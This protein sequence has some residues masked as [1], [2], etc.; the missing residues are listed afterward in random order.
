MPKFKTNT[1]LC[2]LLSTALLG[3]F[4]AKSQTQEPV[5]SYIP[6]SPNAMAFQ[7]FADYPVDFSTGLPAIDIPIYTIAFKDYSFPITASFHAS[8]RSTTFNFSSL[9]MNWELMAT[10]VI[11]REIRGRS[12][13]DGGPHI[14]K[15]PGDLSPQSAHYTELEQMDPQGKEFLPSGGSP[16]KKDNQYDIYTISLNGLSSKFVIKDN[17]NVVFLNYCPYTVTRTQDQFTIIDDKGIS[18]VFGKDASGYG[19]N[20][21]NKASGVNEFTSWFINKITTSTGHSIRFK[22]DVLIVDPQTAIGT[23]AYADTKQITDAG[24]YNDHAAAYPSGNPS[25]QFTGAYTMKF[26]DATVSTGDEYY[27]GYIKDIEFD[28]GTISFTY[29]GTPSQFLLSSVV[30]RNSLGA[31]IKAAN[32]IYFSSLPGTNLPLPNNNSR[33][34]QN[35]NFM[36]STGAIAEKY[37]FEY[38][39][40][41]TG[42]NQTSFNLHKDWWGYSN[43]FNVNDFKQI[44]FTS[45]DV[46]QKSPT[47]YNATVN[48]GSGESCKMP[49]SAASLVGMIKM[50][51]YPTG[52]TS[53]FFYQS[54]RYYNN[55]LDLVKGPGLRIA[56]II[57]HDGLG[58]M[59]GKT[60]EYSGGYLARQPEVN[61][62][63]YQKRKFLIQEQVSR[64]FDVD[65]VGSFQYRE[66]SSDPVPEI[67]AAY[68]IP[69]YYGSVTEYNYSRNNTKNGRTVY[70]YTYPS[71]KYDY[72]YLSLPS[73]ALGY[74]GY[75]TDGSTGEQGV[76]SFQLNEWSK[77]QLS[78]K[79]VEKWDPVSNS[80]KEISSQR[81]T[82]TKLNEVIIPQS[83]MYRY[84]EFPTA[85]SGEY[86]KT[87]ITNSDYYWKVYALSDR[88]I[89]SA[90]MKPEMEI[91]TT[92]DDRGIKLIDTVQYTYGNLVHVNPT[93]IVNRKSNQRLTTTYIA[94]PSDYNPQIAGFTSSPIEKVTT[95]LIGANTTVLSAELTIYQGPVVNNIS[96]TE[97]A[98]P[99]DVAQFKFSNRAAGVLPTAGTAAAFQPDSR[100]VS[101]VAFNSF[102]SRY[103]PTQIT[104]TGNQLLSYIWGY[105]NIYPIAEAKNTPRKNIFYTSFEDSNEG[106]ST[107]GDAKTGRFSKTGGFSTTLS[108]IDNGT[109]ILSYWYKNGSSW[110]Y[111]TEKKTVSGG[112]YSI[113]LAGQVDE[114][115]FYPAAAQMT[116]YTYQPLI[117]Q[118]TASNI[119][120]RTSAFEYDTYNRL[121]VVRDQDNNVVKK[122]EYSF[123]N[124]L[125][126]NNNNAQGTYR[127]QGCPE[128][129]RGSDEVYQVSNGIH[130]SN[131]DQSDANNK[132]N[133]DVTWNGQLY[134][135]I[136]GRC[137][138]YTSGPRTVEYQKV[139]PSGQYGTYVNYTS[140]IYTSAIDQADADA[141]VQNDLNTNGQNTANTQGSC[142]TES[143]LFRSDA[144]S[145]DIFKT[146][147]PFGSTGNLYTHVNFA[148]G[149]YKSVRSK[150]DANLQ[151][152]AAVNAKQWEAD[153]NGS[154]TTLPT[155]SVS[156]YNSSSRNVT[157]TFNLKNSSST[158]SGSTS[159]SIAPGP[160][161]MTATIPQGSYDIT[162]SMGDTGNSYTAFVNG[163]LRQTGS[164]MT[165]LNVIPYSISISN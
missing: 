80:Y 122:Y 21:Y 72:D 130:Y 78:Q 101:N 58:N 43:T 77:S 132:A 104:A 73:K 29:A 41:V 14:E 32:L 79:T 56:K 68:R 48:V 124:P 127:K 126:Y 118:S 70:N 134:A 123:I 148:E 9:G 35:I 90:I 13:I 140:G 154:C 129:F 33:T 136:N 38:Y 113:S 2:V 91:T 10:G 5:K 84:L 108:N 111:S 11:N 20:E 64:S 158:S 153:A 150:E 146:G 139:C 26:K 97:F 39:P 147:C 19:F 45:A 8:G 89:N 74:T 44:P 152:Q 85:T 151:A 47:A 15:A 4:N 31:F 63:Y 28:N 155:M 87:A 83:A 110:N 17:G 67:Q 59:T 30:V 144:V 128:G 6:P 163:D 71:Y 3:F 119:N 18:Y 22:Y 100:Y 50:I 36:D 145:K 161:S 95:Q 52:G 109:Y 37:G 96:K 165:Y 62:F 105:N 162:I 65:F 82:Y 27:I 86:E 61:D 51:H 94:Y 54:N 1:L 40:G 55:N 23:R 112:T 57:S 16:T 24:V 135:N 142:L 53:E 107:S 69:V 25:G 114:I 99:L 92:T 12:D 125:Y 156:L 164:T 115:K 117:G 133:L 34:I 42:G 102:D 103:N 76:Y 88:T 75:I 7:K 98:D 137:F 149:A 60:Y 143:Q 81:L 157:I 121:K 93:K 49:D 120:D 116:A 131:I 46:S 138:N 159:V 106:N 66:Y 141:K 160:T